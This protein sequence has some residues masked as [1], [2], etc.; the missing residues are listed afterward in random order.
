MKIN[1]Y[2]VL[3]RIC[4]CVAA[5]LWCNLSCFKMSL[6]HFF[7]PVKKKLPDSNGELSVTISLAAIRELNQE[8]VEVTERGKRKAYKK[9]SD[10][11]K[12]KIVHYTLQ[13]SNAADV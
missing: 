1:S 6:Y 3:E 8:V 2:E 5:G 9:I 11:L 13:N 10:S 4:T 12:G 7:K